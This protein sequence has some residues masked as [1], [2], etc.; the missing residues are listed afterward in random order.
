MLS[1][2]KYVSNKLVESFWTKHRWLPSCNITN[3]LL[4][5]TGLNARE[6]M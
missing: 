1:Y 5:L 2:I 3:I 4:I 6:L